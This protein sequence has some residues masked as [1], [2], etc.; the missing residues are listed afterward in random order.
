MTPEGRVKSKIK[1]FL[2]T[3]GEGLYYEMPVP[4]GFGKAG[5]DF[6]CCHH[7]F[8]FAIEAKKP[9]GKPTARQELT[10]QA[11]R[12]AGGAVFVIDGDET[13]NEFKR[14]MALRE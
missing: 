7:G 11:I 8:Y 12:R 1:R 14:W 13:L 6:H 3:Y 9:G 2:Q 4:S 5:L 10:I